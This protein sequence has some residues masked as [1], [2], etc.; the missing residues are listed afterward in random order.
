AP[1][2]GAALLRYDWPLNIRELEQCLLRAAALAE[3]D[4]LE[5][6]HLPPDVAQPRSGAA[7]KSIAP[8]PKL[9][10]KDLALRKRLI[11][12]LDEHEGN[13]TEV[14]RAMGKARMQVHRWMNKLGIAPDRFR[15]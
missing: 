3:R 14:A 13:L 6:E 5:L 8:P 11:E 7:P 9:S 12:L 4:A 2:A 1:D 10:E 15:K